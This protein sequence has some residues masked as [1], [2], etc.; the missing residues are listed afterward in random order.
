LYFGYANGTQCATP[1]DLVLTNADCSPLV[2]TFF[3][4]PVDY[5]SDLDGD[6]LFGDILDDADPAYCPPIRYDV[7]VYPNLMVI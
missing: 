2:F 3:A 5:D 7:T 1:V 4:V 6:M